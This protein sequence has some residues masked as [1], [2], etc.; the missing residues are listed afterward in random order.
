MLMY[1]NLESEICMLQL[2]VDG[3]GR[4]LLAPRQWEWR[5]VG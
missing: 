4:H 2:K 1:M 5:T 3:E